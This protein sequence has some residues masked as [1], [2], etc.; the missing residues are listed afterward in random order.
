MN[1][2]ELYEIADYQNANGMLI[3]NDCMKIMREL[4]DENKKIQLTITDIPYGEVNRKDNG[5]RNLNKENADIMTF[6]LNEFLEEV[7]R[8]TEG[9]IIIFCGIEQV[10]DIA[11]F[12]SDK[13]KKQLGTMRHLIWTKSNPSPMN[14]DY[15][16]L[17]AIENAVWFKK[18][19][20]GV[21][22]GHCKKNYFS[23]PCGKSKLHPTEKNH[24]LI[25]E[26]ILD[27]SNEGDIIFDPCCGSG[28]HCLVAKENNRMFIGCELDKK[29]F[30]IAK[31]RFNV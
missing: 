16:Y 8:I 22:N 10:S 28:S 27:N 12:F 30:E 6:D 3:N 26:L 24:D 7:Y 25:K 21:F 31:G 15:I 18:R 5:L 4:N 14:G 17:S 19:K 11:R 13:Q 23:Y 20:N 1:I 29:Y 9:T 2:A